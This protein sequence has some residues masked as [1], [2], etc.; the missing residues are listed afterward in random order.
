MVMLIVSL[1][2]GENH[3]QRGWQAVKAISPRLKTI[4]FRVQFV[5]Q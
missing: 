5:G 4:P 3:R 1:F 2:L